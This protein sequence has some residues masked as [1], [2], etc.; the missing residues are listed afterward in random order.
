MST[1]SQGYI[2]SHFV[3]DQKTQKCAMKNP[4]ILIPGNKISSMNS[5]LP[6]LEVAS[7]DDYSTTMAKWDCTTAWGTNRLSN[8]R[9]YGC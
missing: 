6:V 8:V 2:S 5:V 1:L 9:I 7:E 4:L 3:T